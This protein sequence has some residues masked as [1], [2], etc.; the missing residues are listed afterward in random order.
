VQKEEEKDGG[1]KLKS[2]RRVCSSVISTAKG[3]ER[4]ILLTEENRHNRC[5]RKGG[6]D[7][8]DYPLAFEGMSFPLYSRGRKTGARAADDSRERKESAR[9]SYERKEKKKEEQ[10]DN[11]KR[12]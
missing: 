10:D 5:F 12:P 2:G 6:K 4:L 9:C 3:R 7:M 8:E 11:I 1:A